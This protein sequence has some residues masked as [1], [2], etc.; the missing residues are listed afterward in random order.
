MFS[1]EALMA[2]A[3]SPARSPVASVALRYTSVSMADAPAAA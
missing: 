1:L 3:P 2:A